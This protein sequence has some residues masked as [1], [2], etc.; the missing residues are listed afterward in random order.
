MPSSDDFGHRPTRIDIDRPATLINSDGDEIAV[1]VRDISRS[2]FRVSTEESL[3][4][5]EKVHLR[6][7]RG[8]EFAARIRWALGDEAGGEFVGGENNG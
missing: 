5:G 2:G 4:I 7:E 8:K 6:V 3:R 1:V